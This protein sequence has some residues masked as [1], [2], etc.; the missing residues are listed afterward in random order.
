ML[1][2]IGGTAR[3]AATFGQGMDPVW[4]SDVQC[5]GSEHNLTSCTSSGFGVSNCAHTLDAGVTCDGPT[6]P[7]RTFIF[8]VYR[9]SH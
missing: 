2:K 4:L 1:F 5:A 9:I 7:P 8:E 3:L 6:T